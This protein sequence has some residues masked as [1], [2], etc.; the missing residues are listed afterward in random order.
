VIKKRTRVEKSEAARDAMLKR[1]EE[2][3]KKALEARRLNKD[4]REKEEK[5]YSDKVEKVNNLLKNEDI[6]EKKYKSQFDKISDKLEYVENTLKEER[7]YKSKKRAEKVKSKEVEVEKVEEKVT[8]R[9]EIKETEA[10]VSSMMNALP[11]YRTMKF[12]RNIR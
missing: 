10:S 4:K 6:F 8:P 5:E 12:G 7:E 1:L 2:G 9:V 11:D 3:R